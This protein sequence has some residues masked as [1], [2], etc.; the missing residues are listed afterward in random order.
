MVGWLVGWLVGWMH[1]I[2]ETQV[3]NKKICSEKKRKEKKID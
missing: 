3:D 1:S 2:V